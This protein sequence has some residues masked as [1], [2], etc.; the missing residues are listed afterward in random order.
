MTSLKITATYSGATDWRGISY[1]WVD[2][3]QRSDCLRRG[4]GLP[5]IDHPWNSDPCLHARL[6]HYAHHVACNGCGWGGRAG[7]DTATPKIQH[8]R[9]KLNGT[10]AGMNVKSAK[11]AATQT[12]GK[13]A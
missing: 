4:S 11:Y 6:L 2:V 12:D 5:E 3:S 10:Q 13:R 1:C 8:R 9:G 7:R